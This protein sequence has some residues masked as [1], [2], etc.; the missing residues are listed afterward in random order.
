MLNDINFFLGGAKITTDDDQFTDDFFVSM[1]RL[2]I[3]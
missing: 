2:M 3:S 1:G